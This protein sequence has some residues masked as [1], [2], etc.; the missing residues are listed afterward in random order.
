MR[1]RLGRLN[2]KALALVA[3]IGIAVIASSVYLSGAF[4]SKSSGNAQTVDMQIIGGVGVG[5]VDTYVPANFTVT[6]GKNVTLT[7]LNT[8]DNVHGIAIPSFGVKNTLI[9]PGDTVRVWFIANQTGTFYYS[10]PP[11]DCKGGYGGVCNS[12]QH[13]WGWITV[14]PP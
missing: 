2:P 12:V 7:I 14:V 13:M 8:D 5:T 6:E 11:G 9:S 4:G 10:E 3:V 1:H